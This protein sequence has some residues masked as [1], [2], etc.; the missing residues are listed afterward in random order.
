MLVLK[1]ICRW[2]IEKKRKNKKQKMPL[3]KCYAVLEFAVEK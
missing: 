2:R 3:T 1:N